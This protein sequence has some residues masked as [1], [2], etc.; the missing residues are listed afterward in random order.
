MKQTV[1]NTFYAAQRLYG[2]SRTALGLS[3]PRPETLT[4]FLL[5]TIADVASEMAVGPGRLREQFSALLDRGFRCLSLEEA[6]RHL[7][8]RTRPDQ[9]SFLITFDD[10]YLSNLSE[11]VPF[12]EELD[13]FATVFVT[14]DLIEGRAAPPWRSDNQALLAHY[15]QFSDAFR[16]MSWADVRELAECDRVTIGSHTLSHPLVGLL[17]DEKMQDELVRS[18]ELLENQIN[19]PVLDFSYPFGVRQYGAYSESSEQVVRSAGYRCSFSAE[20]GRTRWSDGTWLIPRIS[21]TNDDAGI[22]T[23]A[24]AGGAYDWVGLAQRTFQRFVP[25]PHVALDRVDLVSGEG[26]RP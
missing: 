11:G 7:E 23:V 16:P 1:K 6:I 24:K 25:N 18:R 15:Q 17:D 19:R 12:L 3:R 20:I 9:P 5:H 21:L 4:V 26:D 13:L 22:D 14:V 10:G 8:N 2:R